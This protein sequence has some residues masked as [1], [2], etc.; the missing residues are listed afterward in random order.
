[1][2]RIQVQKKDGRIEDFSQEKLLKS[3]LGAGATQDQAQ[4]VVQEI[5]RWL[6]DLYSEEIVET[7]M[8]RNKVIGFLNEKNPR[9]AKSYQEY[10]KE[11]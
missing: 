1:M 8:I 6:G 9:A 11:A 7:K 4:V 5:E 2:N 10:K 3:L